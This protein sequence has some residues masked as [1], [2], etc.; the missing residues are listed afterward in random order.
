M[1]SCSDDWY[2]SFPTLS[3]PHNPHSIQTT[4]GKNHIRPDTH[5]ANPSTSP[6]KLQQTRLLGSSSPVS[7]S[8]GGDYWRHGPS[9]LSPPPEQIQSVCPRVAKPRTSHIG[10][11]LRRGPVYKYRCVDPIISFLTRRR[12][13]HTCTF[14]PSL[15]REYLFILV[16]FSTC[17]CP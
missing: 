12:T 15:V 6:A 2:F 1:I 11:T 10:A 16:L 9:S 17:V 7:T 8:G 3:T 14:G 4:T 5:T 13:F